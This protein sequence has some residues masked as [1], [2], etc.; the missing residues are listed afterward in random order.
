MPRKNKIENPPLERFTADETLFEIRDETCWPI[1]RGQHISL[2]HYITREKVIY[3]KI[4]QYSFQ[5]QSI[6]NRIYGRR[7]Q[8][9]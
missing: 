7:R 1:G 2:E 4:K 9:C 6:I 8:D 5:D 3:E